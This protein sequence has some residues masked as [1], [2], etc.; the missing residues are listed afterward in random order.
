MLKMINSSINPPHELLNMVCV[1]VSG[2]GLIVSARSILFDRVII[3]FINLYR[4]SLSLDVYMD[5]VKTFSPKS[6]PPISL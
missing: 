3:T 6:C 5:S 4:L 1:C 2:G